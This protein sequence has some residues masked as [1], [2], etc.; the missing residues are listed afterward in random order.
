MCILDIKESWSRVI[1]SRFP[2]WITPNMLTWFRLC[3][4]VPIVILIWGDHTTYAIVLVVIALAADL[5]DGPLARARHQT[6]V[7]GAGLDPIADKALIA[8]VFIPLGVLIL[9]LLLVAFILVLELCILIGS[10]MIACIAYLRSHTTPE[11]VVTAFG[12]Y[13][14]ALYGAGSVMLLLPW[15]WPLTAAI[16]CFTCGGFMSLASTIQLMTTH[17]RPRQALGDGP[18]IEKK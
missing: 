3:L 12:K 5:F 2:R 7:F 9:P 10:F 6:T 15:Q 17:S 4:T 11:V 18:R 16:L 8:A 14:M 1:V 13:K